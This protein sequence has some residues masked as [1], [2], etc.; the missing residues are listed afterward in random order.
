MGQCDRAAGHGFGAVAVVVAIALALRVSNA[1][2]APEVAPRDHHATQLPDQVVAGPVAQTGMIARVRRRFCAPEPCRV[3]AAPA[4]GGGRGAPA[5]RDRWGGVSVL[6][7]GQP[8]DRVLRQRAKLKLDIDIA[9]WGRAN[10]GGARTSPG[11]A[12]G[13]ATASSCLSPTTFGPIFRVSSDRGGEPVA[14]DAPGHAHTTRSPIPA[15]FCRMVRHFSLFSAVGSP[16]DR[17][18]LLP[19]RSMGPS[20][21]KRLLD[22]ETAADGPRGNRLVRPAGHSGLRQSFDPVRLGL[23]GNSVAAPPKTHASPEP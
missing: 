12:R 20:C 17:A 2:A 6:A 15:V 23:A 16:K 4:G 1:P 11:A 19:R 18:C 21:K 10:P 9:G 8:L 7:A 3:A 13:A 22:A 14:V 5:G